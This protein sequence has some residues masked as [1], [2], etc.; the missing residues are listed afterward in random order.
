MHDLDKNGKLDGVEL[1]KA[2][3]H[4]HAGEIFKNLFFS[5]ILILIGFK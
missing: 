5:K 4:F 1:I 2:I 3:T